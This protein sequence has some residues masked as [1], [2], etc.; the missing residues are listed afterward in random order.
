MDANQ[1][2]WDSQLPISFFVYRIAVHET[3]GFALFHLTFAHS[4]QLPVDIL[5]GH[6][7]PATLSSYPQFIKNVHKQ[8]GSIL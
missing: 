2:T 1:D 3:T 7:L 6:V 8:D 5:V 4:P